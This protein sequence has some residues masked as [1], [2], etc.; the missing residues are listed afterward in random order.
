M[1]KDEKTSSSDSSSYLPLEVGSFNFE[2]L[3]SPNQAL[4]DANKELM[5]IRNKDYDWRVLN[6][7]CFGWT[8]MGVLIAQ[9]GFVFTL[10]LMAFSSDSLGDIQWLVGSFFMTLMAQTFLTANHLIKWLFTEIDYKAH[11]L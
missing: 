11:K 5:K 8:I 2:Q 4:L 10:I 6:R 9:H 7:G 3:S 1:R